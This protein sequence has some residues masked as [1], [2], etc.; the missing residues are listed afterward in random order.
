MKPENKID[1]YFERV[2]Q[3][4]PLISTEKVHQIINSPKVMARLKGKPY[5]LLKFTIMT[6]IFAIILSAFLF[7][8][9][10]NAEDSRPVGNGFSNQRIVESPNASAKTNHPQTASLTPT[11]KSNRET[12][13]SRS[14]STKNKPEELNEV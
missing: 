13:I 9:V 7:W 8:P 12:E 4:P 11:Q 1:S 2:K 10:N 3:N 6:T 5:N 14:V